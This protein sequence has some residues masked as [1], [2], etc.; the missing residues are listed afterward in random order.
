[1]ETLGEQAARDIKQCANVCDTYSKKKLLV[2]VLVG[3]AWDA[4][5]TEFL[6]R[7]TKLR[8]DFKMAFT[9]YTVKSA[10]EMHGKVHE[11]GEK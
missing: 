9:L 11:I 4:R 2:K 3:P 6:D 8:S 1:M 7:F 10:S 5:L